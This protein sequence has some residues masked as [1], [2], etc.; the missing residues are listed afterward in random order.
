MNY[1]LRKKGIYY[2]I[3]DEDYQK[4]LSEQFFLGNDS[5]T[6]DIYSKII[7]H[8]DIKPNEGCYD[9]LC[10]NCFYHSMKS[11]FPGDKELNKHCPKCSKNIGTENKGKII[12]QKLIVKRSDYAS[13]FK[14]K[15]K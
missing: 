15:R 14:D 7:E 3:Y 1:Q 5:K 6:H 8:F 10:K 12:S 9:C 11:G 2:P 4:H 13:I